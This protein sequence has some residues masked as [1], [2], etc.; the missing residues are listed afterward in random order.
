MTK[1]LHTQL[2]DD[3]RKEISEGHLRPGDALPSEAELGRV[4]S[5]SRITVRKALQ[6]LEHEGLVAAAAGRGRVVRDQ[7]VYDWHLVDY[8][9][10]HRSHPDLDGWASDVVDQGGTPNETVVAVEVVDPPAEVKAKLAL[11]AEGAALLRRRVRS[12]NGKPA[13]L[14]SSYF[15]YEMVKGTVFML[16]GS[17]SAQ[18][19]L[20]ASIGRPQR[21]KHHE[22]TARNASP[23]EA[24]E[25]QLL[26]GT[27]L[28]Q[29]IVVGYDED[30]VA[31][32]CMVT[33]A[34][35]DV[36][37]LVVDEENLS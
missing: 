4:H 16:P 35:S 34:A 30:D 29:H 11:G 13:Q 36:A 8:E 25:L 2:A 31:V 6:T 26:P 14:S 9:K 20:L 33:L 1:P 32:R 22:I 15:P 28:I 10:K 12:I 7:K 18:G 5:I 23:D 17:Q 21:R 27:P 37:R 3:L 24:E 19:G